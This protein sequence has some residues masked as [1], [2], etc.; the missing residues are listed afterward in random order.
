MLRRRGLLAAL[1]AAAG[2][3]AIGTR[4]LAAQAAA[5]TFRPVYHE[6]DEWFDKVAGRHRVVVDVTSAVGVA[7]VLVANMIP[8][9]RIVPAGVIA[10]TRAREYG[11]SVRHVG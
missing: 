9:S 1:G 7:D 10:V 2:A 5:T 3:L 11:Y 4:R 6:Q 8:S